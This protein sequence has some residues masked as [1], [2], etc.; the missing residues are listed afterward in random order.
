MTITRQPAMMPV[1]VCRRLFPAKPPCSPERARG[2]LFARP[3][4]FC[5]IVHQSPRTGKLRAAI[6]FRNLSAWPHRS[7]EKAVRAAVSCVGWLAG[8]SRSGADTLPWSSGMG[9]CPADRQRLTSASADRC[10]N[11]TGHCQP[12]TRWATRR[13]AKCILSRR[14]SCTKDARFGLTE[15]DDWTARYPFANKC[16]WETGATRRPAWV[17]ARHGS[18]A[19]ILSAC[20]SFGEFSPLF[21][22]HGASLMPDLL[23]PTAIRFI[24]T[25]K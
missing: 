12:A 4:T 21:C 14:A 13:K 22:N 20:H 17:V 8:K 1:P 24:D 11:K 18:G 3:F 23:T 2:F 10:T 19:L 25:E 15:R 7:D 16:G 5:Y 6:A 9:W